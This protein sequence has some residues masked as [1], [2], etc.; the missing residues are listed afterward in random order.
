MHRM[1]NLNINYKSITA[2]AD[3]PTA[4]KIKSEFSNSQSQ[5]RGILHHPIRREGGGFQQRITG[6]EE[7][8]TANHNTGGFYT[9]QSQHSVI[10][11]QPITSQGDFTTANHRTGGFYITGG[12]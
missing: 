9:I 2:E 5:E 3:F 4:N 12:F 6:Q 10:L 1:K 8:P 11:H 7:F